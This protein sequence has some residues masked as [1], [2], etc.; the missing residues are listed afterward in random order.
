MITPKCYHLS[1][2]GLNSKEGSSL[3][4]E[5]IKNSNWPVSESEFI[6]INDNI[7]R[8]FYSES[9]LFRNRTHPAIIRSMAKFFFDFIDLSHHSLSYQKLKER[10]ENP[11]PR[12]NSNYNKL[13]NHQIFNQNYSQN[14]LNR[15]KKIALN[16]GYKFLNFN[17]NKSK[18]V[19]VLENPNFS[20]KRLA[21]KLSL[22]C[23][24][25]RPSDLQ[26]LTQNK[27]KQL[28]SQQD[29]PYGEDIKK[30]FNTLVELSPHIKS[31]LSEEELSLISSKWELF[32]IN[33]YKTY[34]AISIIVNELSIKN[35]F[36]ISAGN[37]FLRLVAESVKACGGKVYGIGHANDLGMLVIPSDNVTIQILLPTNY[38]VVNSKLNEQI[39]LNFKK[40]YAVLDLE[41]IMLSRPNLK[42]LER[43]LSKNTLLARSNTKNNNLIYVLDP[44]ITDRR[45]KGDLLFWPY[46]VKLIREIGKQLKRLGL[47]YSFKARAET[48]HLTKLLYKDVFEHF[49]IE[50]FENILDKGKAFIFPGFIA[51]S[52][53]VPALFSKKPIIIFEETFN[54][55]W[56]E[57]KPMLNDRCHIV[58]SHLDSSDNLVFKNEDFINILEKK[59][60]DKNFNS[61]FKTFFY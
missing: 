30:V 35:L 7:L 47:K 2:E 14:F 29:A 59:L 21:S 41:P 57:L 54:K 25:I 27:I 13:F 55:S 52:T 20:F 33:S 24:Y 4:L 19:Y 46:Q 50:P 56:D 8:V 12:L 38:F 15:S 34:E 44:W 45:F 32:Y 60:N 58:S 49:E 61:L 51:T 11:F 31:T 22:S 3:I 1:I 40:K 36:I 5:Q 42:N 28:E 23:F 53:L 17:F 39:I 37:I 18:R 10:G 9:T 6:N 26:N 43:S 16:V 48:I